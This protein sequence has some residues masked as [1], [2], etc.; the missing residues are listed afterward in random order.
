MQES[1]AIKLLQ[2]RL[3][4]PKL[5]DTR[6]VQITNTIWTQLEKRNEWIYFIP[7]SDII[8]ILFPEKEPID[9]IIRGTGK[10]SIS[11]GRK[12]YTVVPWFASII[13]SG[14]VLVIQSTRISKRI[15]P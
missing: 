12:R 15:S 6:I 10:L 8:S 13:R 1:C 9:V 4:I 7:N 3:N 5:C 11:S 2:P 14:N